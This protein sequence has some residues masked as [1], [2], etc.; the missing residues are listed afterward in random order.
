MW[1]RFSKEIEKLIL[2][3]KEVPSYSKEWTCVRA[4]A[5]GGVGVGG[6][7]ETSKLIALIA[8]KNNVEKDLSSDKIN[9]FTLP[10]E[11]SFYHNIKTTIALFRRLKTSRFSWTVWSDVISH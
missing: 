11:G 1:S 6:A 10:K 2:N 9:C 7:R 4:R 3:E 5:Q 8:S